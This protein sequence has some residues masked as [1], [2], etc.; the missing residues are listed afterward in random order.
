MRIKFLIGLCFLCI[1][2]AKAQV[3]LLLSEEFINNQRKWLEESDDKRS[4]KI[5]G[6]HY[7]MEHKREEGTWLY[8]NSI[9]YFAYE[10]DFIIETQIRQNTGD[11]QNHYGLIWGVA[12]SKNLH[13][14]VLSSNGFFRIYSYD[15]GEYKTVKSWTR[16]SGVK[17]VG[18]FNVLKLKREKD[19]ILYYINDS[20]VFQ[21]PAPLIFGNKVG[22]I[23]NKQ[24]E[25]AADYLRVYQE[26]NIDLTDDAIQKR[27]VKNMGENINTPASEIMP[28]IA[29]DGQ[30]LYFVRKNYMGNLGAEKKDDIWFSK[31]QSDSTWGKAE[32][33]G[34]PINNES[35][36]QIIY[37]SPDGNT[38][39]VG[40]RYKANG[41]IA[42]RGLSLSRRN[43]KGWSIPETIEIED[44]YNQANEHSFAVSSNRKIMILS[45][46]RRDTKGEKDLYV[47]FQISDKKYTAP[48]NLGP[49][50]NSRYD[51]TTPFLAADGK[52]LYFASNGHPGYGGVDIFVS[53]RLDD[54]WTNWS[55]PL[56]MGPEIN[57]PR[58]DAYYT[59]PASGDV[60][61]FVSSGHNASSTDIFMVEIPKEVRP[62][63][64]SLVAGQ[65]LHAKTQKPLS[66]TISFHRSS[67]YQEIGKAQSNS[68]DGFY[69]MV[70]PDGET[71]SLAALREGYYPA[72]ER[73]DLKKETEYQEIIQNI[74]L[75]PIA[76]GEIIPLAH[77]DFDEQQKLKKESL[78]EAERLARLLEIYPD[79]KI[80]L[81]IT[82]KDPKIAAQQLNTLKNYLIA[83][84][85]A[86][87]RLKEKTKGG[88][89]SAEFK[90]L[91]LGGKELVAEDK[92]DF[93]LD[94]DTDNLAIGHTFRLN[95]LYFLADS[96]SFTPNSI[97]SLDELQKFLSEHPNIVIE[98][99]G[100]TNGLPS[101]EYCDRL[102]SERAKNVVLYLK[103]KGVSASQL[104]YKGYGKRRPI[105]DNTTELGRQRNQ[106]VEIKVLEL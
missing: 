48:I 95:N 19:N 71:Y 49:V 74:Y 14:F 92:G 50:I 33:L 40:N 104:Q 85:V 70:L 36:N 22:Y 9:N 34:G 99:G 73:I 24:I 80:E 52:T 64:V 13:A 12:D 59:I 42:G 45:L 97:R 41:E 47:S 57:T 68:D 28:V 1:G 18:S 75:Y 7:I 43:K 53:K 30:T 103:A 78:S 90:I 23:L 84:G 101:H 61:Y 93:S 46:K 76:L 32:N 100:H 62:D 69:K 60:V 54:T 65:V 44:Y 25:I 79:M 83:E 58:W 39:I 27:K 106:R 82:D 51:E 87:A 21:E 35:H 16:H 67:D 96:S 29:A 105:A 8:F 11:A 5:G 88:N 2:I 10:K 77:L 98:I 31:R 63:P 56:N 86:P 91:S 38:M 81:A 20:L 15:N 55:K 6:G 37:I 102:S 3:Q 66:A 89:P 94:I 26:H 4:A 17:P 72:S